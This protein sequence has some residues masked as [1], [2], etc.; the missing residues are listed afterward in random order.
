MAFHICPTFLLPSAGFYWTSSLLSFGM[1]LPCRENLARAERF[2]AAQ[3]HR[4]P[5][6]PS[7]SDLCLRRAGHVRT[8]SHLHSFSTSHP[9]SPGTVPGSSQALLQALFNVTNAQCESPATPDLGTNPGTG[10]T[11]ITENKAWEK[12]CKLM[13]WGDAVPGNPEGRTVE[14]CQ[15]GHGFWPTQ[16]VAHHADIDLMGIRAAHR[17]R[18]GWAIYLLGFP[19]P[20]VLHWSK[21]TFYE[22][23]PRT[24]GWCYPAFPVLLQIQ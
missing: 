8:H 1:K 5:S 13:I 20:L 15:A 11:I 18:K 14:P 9:C 7:L 24:C 23:L 2:H 21:L 12:T 3:P 10:M 6:A 16:L 4:R 22:K 17:G 19:S